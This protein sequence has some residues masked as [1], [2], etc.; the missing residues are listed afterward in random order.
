MAQNQQQLEYTLKVCSLELFGVFFLTGTKQTDKLSPRNQVKT[1][2]VGSRGDDSC[3]YTQRDIFRSGQQVYQQELLCITT[4]HA[5]ILH[6]FLLF[7]KITHTENLNR[8][9]AAIFL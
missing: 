8:H 9:K 1:F 6:Y 3:T 2:D 5:V 4:I 7:W